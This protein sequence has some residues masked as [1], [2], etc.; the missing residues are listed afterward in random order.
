MRHRHA[1]AMTCALAMAA[2]QAATADVVAH[3][4]FNGFV[5]ES[6][7][8]GASTGS[9]SFDFRGVSAGASAMGGTVLNG[10]AGAIAGESFAITGSSYNGRYVQID[11]MSGGESDL[12]LSFATRRSGTGFAN[13]RIDTLLDGT[14]TT[15]A[16]FNPSPTEW[17]MVSVNLAAAGIE[18]GAASLRIHF[19]GATSSLGSVRID[20]LSI[21]GTPVPGPGA[22]GVAALGTAIAGRRRRRDG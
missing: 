7:V 21:T 12:A 13:N 20:N 15:I 3:W 6:G 22:L 8:V 16:N 11:F 2:T 4:N 10:L 18:A 17:V 19:D 14:W 1:G 5:P 9:G